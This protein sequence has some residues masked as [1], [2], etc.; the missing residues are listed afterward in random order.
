MCRESHNGQRDRRGATRTE[1]RLTPAP[2][3]IRRSKY[4][5]RSGNLARMSGTDESFEIEFR[6]KE[7]CIY[8]EGRNGFAFD[9]AWGV[10]QIETYVPDEASWD[11][12]VP[13]WPVGRRAIV[14][15]RFMN[16]PEHT[17][18]SGPGYPPGDRTMSRP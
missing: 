6:W 7:Q 13:D 4:R 8:W 11:E 12:L 16:N 17:V 9:G 15:E 18:R 10:T 1:L 14:V 2:K 3:A 5:S